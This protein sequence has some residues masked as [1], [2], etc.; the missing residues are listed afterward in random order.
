MIYRET[1]RESRQR[2][3]EEVH[4]VDAKQQA[5]QHQGETDR[6]LIRA[7]DQARRFA[8]VPYSGFR[9]GA[10][11]LDEKGCLFSGC[12]VENASYGATCCAER[13]AV[14]KAISEGAGKIRRMAV[15][16]D[17]DKPCMPCG[18]CRQVL[19]EFATEDFLLLAA[20]ADG[21]Y[22]AYTIEGLLPDAFSL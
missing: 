21:S 17:Q 4:S 7:A 12:N 3:L 20:A 11:L 5:A 18:I 8:Y 2:D 10:A 9:V 16:C 15:V 13:T 14:F 19:A 1:G 22:R 6:A